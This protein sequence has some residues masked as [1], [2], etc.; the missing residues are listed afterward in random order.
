MNVYR[1]TVPSNLIPIAPCVS[2]LARQTVVL[3]PSHRCKESLGQGK[4]LIVG[5][6]LDCL[7]S[8]LELSLKS[9]ALA[10]RCTS[11]VGWKAFRNLG[12]TQKALHASKA[13]CLH[14]I[15]DFYLR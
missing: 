10:V 11:S 2:K 12:A 13:G 7:S 8:A 3:T 9:D 14:V 5:S 15:D 6:V 1:S 4:L